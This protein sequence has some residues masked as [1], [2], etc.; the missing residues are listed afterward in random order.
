[1]T[2]TDPQDPHRREDGRVR[3][4][5]SDRRFP[6]TIFE[7]LRSFLQTEASS[8]VMLLVAVGIAL[9]WANW[10]G[11]SSYEGFWR[12]VLTV[13]LGRFGVSIDLRHWVDEALMTL[14]FL[15]VGLEIKRE[16]VSGELRDRRAAVLPIAAALGGMAVP[17]LIYLACNAGGPGSR[18]WGIAMPTDIAFAL[19]VLALAIPRAPASVRVF[20]L[21]LAIVDDLLTVVAVAFFYSTRVSAGWLAAAVLVAVVVFLLERI[22]VRVPVFSIALGLCMW[23]ALREAGVSPTLAGVTMGF[24]TPAVPFRPVI[25]GEP[26]A[27]SPLTRLEKL[28]HPWTSYLVV[29]LFALANAGVSFTIGAFDPPGAGGS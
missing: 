7:P 13:P 26:E 23:F 20:L 2:P 18:G 28:L 19:G 3:T 1:M 16:F 10:Q 15:V 8:G 24:L 12:H 6:A 5:R 9:G 17:A 4:W 22:R 14:F 25:A 11:N 29:P 27:I 21:S